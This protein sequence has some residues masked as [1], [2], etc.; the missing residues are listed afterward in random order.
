MTID[1]TIHADD[2]IDEL[3]ADRCPVCSKA[4]GEDH[5]GRA[6]GN[7]ICSA[8]GRESYLHPMDELHLGYDGRPWLHKLCNGKLVKT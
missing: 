6:G 4:E 2:L 3:L 8:C 5:W 1:A 7:A